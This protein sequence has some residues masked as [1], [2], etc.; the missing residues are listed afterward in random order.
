MS[1][2]DFDADPILICNRPTIASD[3]RGMQSGPGGAAGPNPSPGIFTFQGR[4]SGITSHQ[5]AMWSTLGIDCDAELFTVLGGPGSGSQWLQ[6]GDS[7]TLDDGA[8]AP[9]RYR[10]VGRARRVAKGN[11]GNYWKFPL[12]CEYQA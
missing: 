7:L 9:V 12:K 1:L 5:Q 2:L 11:I 8:E 6:N 4:I 3:S 10:I